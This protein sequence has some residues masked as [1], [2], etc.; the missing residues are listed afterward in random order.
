MAVTDTRVVISGAGPTGLMLACELGLAGIDVLVLERLPEPRTMEARAG[1]LHIRTMET[2]DQRSLLDRFSN[3][4]GRRTVCALLRPPAR[5]VR[6]GHAAS[7]RPRPRAVRGGTAA[8]GA[9]CGAWG[10]GATRC[11]D[12]GV[13]PGRDWCRGGTRRRPRVRAG[14]LVGCDGGRST[15]R[16]LAGIGLPGTPATVTA[17]LGDV[18]LAEPPADDIFQERRAHG[19]FSV[20]SFGREWYRILT[21]EFDHVADRDE[22]AP[23]RPSARGTNSAAAR[24]C[25][26]CITAPT[27]PPTSGSGPRCVAS[28]ANTATSR[29]VDPDQPTA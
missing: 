25:A 16:R 11:R 5:R 7:L 4:A 29:E 19:S 18:E 2:L 24:P 28:T 9:S 22:A 14:Y 15:V 13:H 20:L 12:G 1:G 17:M 6:C 26:T 27:V 21:T 23:W 10:T 3:A 8:G